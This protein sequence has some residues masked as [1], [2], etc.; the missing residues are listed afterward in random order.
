[1]IPCSTR[2]ENRQKQQWVAGCVKQTRCGATTTQNNKRI[3]L[4]DPRKNY[5]RKHA[6]WWKRLLF[7]DKSKSVGCSLES[8]A[9]KSVC[10]YEIKSQRTWTISVSHSHMD[11]HLHQTF[12]WI[13]LHFWPSSCFVTGVCQKKCDRT[14]WRFI[15]QKISG[16]PGNHSQNWNQKGKVEKHWKY[17]LVQDT[18][19]Q[20]LQNLPETIKP[21][22]GWNVWPGRETENMF[23]LCS[24]LFCVCCGVA[25]LET[26]W[27]VSKVGFQFFQMLKGFN[28]EIRCRESVNFAFFFA[29]KSELHCGQLHCIGDIRHFVVQGQV[30]FSNLTLYRTFH[31]GSFQVCCLR[32]R[33]ISDRAMTSMWCVLIHAL[34]LGLIDEIAASSDCSMNSFGGVS[35]CDPYH[36]GAAFLQAMQARSQEVLGADRVDEILSAGAQKALRATCDVSMLNAGACIGNDVCADCFLQGSLVALPNS[37]D[38]RFPNNELRCEGNRTCSQNASSP[39]FEFRETGQ[40]MVCIGDVTCTDVWRFSNLGAV[41]CSSANDGNTCSNSSFTLTPDDALCQNDVCCDGTRVCTN[42]TMDEVESLLC[43]GLLACSDSEVILEQDLYCNATSES[44]PLSSGSTCTDSIFS[45]VVNETHVVD[46]LGDNVCEGSVFNFQDNQL[47]SFECDS[48]A[49]GTGGGAERE[50][51]EGPP[52][53]FPPGCNGM[54]RQYSFWNGIVF[55]DTHG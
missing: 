11:M 43:R 27:N 48:E 1:M 25:F 45:F 2:T 5:W 18:S 49:S 3:N 29:E 30:V 36:D 37:G 12:P 52:R 32:R 46:C 14:T 23:K 17:V 55:G 10:C 15:K 28:W 9:N 7:Y 13:I 19:W 42:S 21:C 53:L 4:N 16:N 8:D 54:S 31:L 35:V 39:A 50:R 22:H 33:A 34:G 24:Q 6:K 40:V 38:P 41:C 26:F 51:L 20:K 47:I 44:N